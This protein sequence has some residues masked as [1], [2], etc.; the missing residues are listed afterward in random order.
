M[1]QSAIEWLKGGRTW[2]PVTGCD[3][4]SDG[5]ANCYARRIAET[6]LRGRCGYPAVRPFRVTLHRDRLLEPVSWKRPRL[7]F[8]GS[9][10]DLLHRDIPTEY[11][12]E[13]LEVMP[14]A[15]QH[16]FLMLTKRASRVAPA[17]YGA[18]E[19]GARALGAGEGIPNLWLG[20]TCE[21]QL[22][23]HTRLAMWFGRPHL[24][25]SLAPWWSNP[26]PLLFVSFEPLL[27]P[28]DVRPW[29]QQPQRMWN[30]A[31]IGCE[32]LPGRKPGRECRDEWVRDLIAQHQEAGVPVF[33]KQLAR[34]GR[35]ESLPEFDG[36]VWDEMP[37]IG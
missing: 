6:R 10:T 28:I 16:T 4:V 9:M 3:P 27:G 19:G 25:W 12:D 21:N 15:P 37:A 18:G 36:R 7:V 13:I 31:I 29:L 33:L 32:K 24:R 2:N 35:V 23:A 5:C 17:F 22:T 11:F 26:S 30:W 14:A 1:A 20:V 8:A 34:N